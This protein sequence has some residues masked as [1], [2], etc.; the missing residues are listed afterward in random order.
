[1]AFKV[2]HL[3]SAVLAVQQ[4]VVLDET[5]LGL[6]AQV[7]LEVV[8]QTGALEERLHLVKVILAGLAHQQEAA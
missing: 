3:V 7:V 2:P 1:M 5:I 4:A 6:V 8:P